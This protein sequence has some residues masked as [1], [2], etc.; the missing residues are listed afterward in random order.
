M[1]VIVT[2]TYKNLAHLSPS[3]AQS[4]FNTPCNMLDRTESQSGERWTV[5]HVTSPVEVI[6]WVRDGIPQTSRRLSIQ[7]NSVHAILLK[8]TKILWSKRCSSSTMLCQILWHWLMYSVWF[9]L[10]SW[11]A[12]SHHAEEEME[13][14]AFSLTVA[15]LYLGNEIRWSKNG[16]EVLKHTIRHFQLDLV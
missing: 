16:W 15:S 6:P 11:W 3:S 12:C 4:T 5:W 10:W 2:C 7:V 8:P 13:W 14:F 9:I 1:D